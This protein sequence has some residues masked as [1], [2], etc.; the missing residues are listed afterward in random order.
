[1]H[2]KIEKSVNEEIYTPV[3]SH[4]KTKKEESKDNMNL[5][6]MENDGEN[7][8]RLSS[9]TDNLKQRKK[10]KTYADVLQ[11]GYE[12]KETFIVKQDINAVMNS[13]KGHLSEIYNDLL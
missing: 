1:M 12:K 5:T 10:K 4:N 9:V 3:E 11:S 2:S 13:A 7:L 8:Q 6:D